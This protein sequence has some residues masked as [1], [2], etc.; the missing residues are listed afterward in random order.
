MS[1]TSTAA[2][3][4]RLRARNQERDSELRAL[5]ARLDESDRRARRSSIEGRVI[6][7]EGEGLDLDRADEVD[8]LSRMS[9][10]DIDN[11]ISRMRKS[12]KFRRGFQVTTRTSPVG[13]GFAGNA[14][15]RGISL[16]DL[17][18][19]PE[20]DIVAGDPT[21]RT[22]I[23]G[24]SIAR[25]ALEMEEAGTPIVARADGHGLHP[26]QRRRFNALR[27]AK[28]TVKRFQAERSEV[29]RT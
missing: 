24:E 13:G 7:L 9:D 3:I 11:E 21:G 15:A 14:M 26:S 16:R 22:R 5:Q 28:A 25:M 4:S 19:P 23:W 1:C 17:D 2:E 10:A 12:Y 8:R 29:T 20:E 27:V 6:Q 18:T